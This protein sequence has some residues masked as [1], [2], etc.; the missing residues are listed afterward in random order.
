MKY[1]TH[2]NAGIFG[3]NFLTRPR[4]VSAP[5]ATSLIVI[6]PLTDYVCYSN[7]L[8]YIIA[9]F[10]LNTITEDELSAVV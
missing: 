3:L 6:E 1:K 8:E 4:K 5:L 7:Y 10:R 2:L 9:V